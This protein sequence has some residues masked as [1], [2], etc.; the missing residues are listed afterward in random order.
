M[1]SIRL[2]VGNH[3]IQEAGTIRQKTRLIIVTWPTGHI[4]RIAEDDRITIQT[5]V[6]KENIGIRRDLN[7]GPGLPGAGAEPDQQK[8][9]DTD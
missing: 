3:R 5:G 4:D 6:D 1:V 8:N 7:I 2:L 9:D